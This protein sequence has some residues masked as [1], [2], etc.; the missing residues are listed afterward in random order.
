MVESE[1]IRFRVVW[2]CNRVFLSKQQQQ[3]ENE[4]SV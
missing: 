3:E 2:N 4:I 1:N